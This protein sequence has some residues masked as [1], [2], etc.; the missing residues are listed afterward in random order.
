MLLPLCKLIHALLC[1]RH[2]SQSVTES[3][4]GQR[5]Y[6][7]SMTEVVLYS[8]CLTPVFS[9]IIFIDHVGWRACPYQTSDWVSFCVCHGFP[10]MFTINTNPQTMTFCWHSLSLKIP[11][12]MSQFYRSCLIQCRHS[13]VFLLVIQREKKKKHY[14]GNRNYK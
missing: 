9:L 10:F 1:H 7:F 13:E 2:L 3:D 5:Q 14:N 11:E 6:L 12:W 4:L 8:M